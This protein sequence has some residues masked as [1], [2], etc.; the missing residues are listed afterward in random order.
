M[1]TLTKK[2]EEIMNIIWQLENAM[3]RDVIKQLPEP[4][5]PNSTVSSVVRILEKKGFVGHKAYGKTHEYYPLISKSAYRKASFKSLMEKYFSGSYKQLVSFMVQEELTE[6][7]AEELN[8]HLE[9][10]LKKKS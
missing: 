9:Q 1:E 8:K 5:P 6:K 7:E 3:V 4:H 2:E 10:Q